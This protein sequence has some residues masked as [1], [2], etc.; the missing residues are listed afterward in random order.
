MD[1]L[2]CYKL[3]SLHKGEMYPL[4]IDKN[5]PVPMGQWM[6]AEDHPTKGFAY[7]PGWHCCSA[8]TAPH[9][10]KVLK[11]GRQRVWVRC[12]VDEYEVLD[13]PESQGGQWYLAKWI[14]LHEVMG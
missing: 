2:W 5:T 7:R 10:K 11:S 3:M 8:M 12:E 9:L 14:K 13:R 1:G 4:F 6:R